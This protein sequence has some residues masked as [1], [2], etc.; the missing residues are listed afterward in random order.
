MMVMVWEHCKEKIWQGY[1]CNVFVT[2]FLVTQIMW[3]LL[4][5]IH[6]PLFVHSAH[7]IVFGAA[8]PPHSPYKP[9]IVGIP[10]WKIPRT[11]RSMRAHESQY[12]AKSFTDLCG[13]ERFSDRWHWI[14]KCFEQWHGRVFRLCERY[15]RKNSLS[16]KRET[17]RCNTSKLNQPTEAKHGSAHASRK[18]RENVNSTV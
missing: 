3:G 6:T 18:A 11:V 9:V 2:V 10:L 15:F 12:C 17:T 7:M 14:S 16:R 1:Y 8:S 4:N 13:Q 5:T